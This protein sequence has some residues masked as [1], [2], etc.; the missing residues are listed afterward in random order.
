[1][2]L[3]IIPDTTVDNINSDTM[4]NN[5]H[6]YKTPLQRFSKTKDALILNDQLCIS[7]E[8]ELSKVNTKFFLHFDNQVADQVRTELNI[9]YPK[10]TFK[11]TKDKIKFNNPIIS[12]LNMKYHY[13]L[14]LKVDKRGLAPLPGILETRKLMKA[15]DRAFVQIIFEPESHDLY[16]SIETAIKDFQKGRMT[17]RIE[18]NKKNISTGLIK[19]GIK[20]LQE[21]LSIISFFLSDDE[22]SFD[23]IDNSEYEDILRR[24]LSQNTLNKS[25]WNGFNTQIR[26]VVDSQDIVRRESIMRSIVTAFKGLNEDNQIVEKRITKKA[27]LSVQP[28]ESGQKQNEK[29]L[30]LIYNRKIPWTLNKNILSAAELGQIIQLPTKAYQEIYK[31]DCIDTREINIPGQLLQGSIEIGKA[32]YRGQSKTIFWP[33]NKNILSLPKIVIG[34]MGSGKSEYTK[35]FCIEAAKKGDS[36]IVF[37]YIKDCELSEAISRQVDCIKINLAMQNNLFAL[38]YPELKPSGDPWNRLKVSNMLSRQIE[39]LLNSLA[40]DPLTPKMS[41]YLDAACKVVFI[42]E[43]KSLNDVINVLLNSQIRNEYIRQAIYESDCFKGTDMEIMDLNSLHDRDDKGKITGTIE[44]KIEG[45]IDRISILNKDIYLRSM[46]KADIN[47]DQNFSQWIDE[48]KRIVIQIPESTFTN[49]QV[50][51]ALVTYYMSRIW[52]SALQRKNHNRICHVI[53]DEI[54]QV[55]T[56]AAMVSGI[57]TEARKFG[58]D[59]CFTIHYMRQFKAL[60]DAV[61]SAGASFMLLAGTEKDNLKALEEELLPFTITE[62]LSLKPFHSLNLI[63]YGNQYARFIS[64]LPTVIY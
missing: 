35:R 54:H 58:M 47:Y 32:N 55:P 41:R 3:Q 30:P 36:L 40:P 34:P 6:Q 24:G 33:D 57:I 51:D 43:N 17:R 44:K 28:S 5:L 23:D 42:H 18:L 46:L 8:I 21:T 38:S 59:F 26:V 53:T 63:N 50:K 31:L 39:Y 13:F 7:Y 25:K 11:E 62:G 14:S 52:L 9:T 49:K 60:H 4:I 27:G 19:A 48:G 37:D 10:S 29:Y 61:R 22:M 15:E 45:I 16:R 64:K 12:E 2:R 56:A 20:T 1:M